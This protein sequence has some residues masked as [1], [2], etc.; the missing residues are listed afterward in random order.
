M[1]TATTTVCHKLY[2]PSTQASLVNPNTDVLTTGGTVE[3][4]I[5]ETIHETTEIIQIQAQEV[6]AERR[7]VRTDLKG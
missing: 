4:T 1:A 6:K 5:V 2:Q 7:T 3:E